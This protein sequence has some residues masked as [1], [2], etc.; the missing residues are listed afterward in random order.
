[1]SEIYIQQIYWNEKRDGSKDFD[2]EKLELG[3]QKLKDEIRI[4]SFDT[5]QKIVAWIIC[6]SL[7]LL[8]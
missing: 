7:S 3:N 5:I 4:P 1:M 8:G 6:G 2:V